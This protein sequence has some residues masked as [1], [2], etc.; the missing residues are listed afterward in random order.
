MQERI[1]REREREEESWVVV[2]S[3]ERQVLKFGEQEV[4]GGE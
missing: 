1:E 3:G 2:V 4:G